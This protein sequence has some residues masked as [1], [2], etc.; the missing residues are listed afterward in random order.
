MIDFEW[1]GLFTH[2]FSIFID[3]RADERQREAANDFW[4]PGRRL[5]GR[6]RECDR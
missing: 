5:A 4:R 1:R 3:A 6:I 2:R